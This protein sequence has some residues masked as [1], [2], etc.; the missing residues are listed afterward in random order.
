MHQTKPPCQDISVHDSKLRPP[1]QPDK[2]FNR[3]NSMRLVKSDCNTVYPKSQAE[4]NLTAKITLQ[5]SIVF[6]VEK[7]YPSFEC[8]LD[9]L[10]QTR[11]CPF[12]GR[13][14]SIVTTGVVGF[15]FL[16]NPSVCLASHYQKAFHQSVPIRFNA[17]C[18]VK[19]LSCIF[20]GA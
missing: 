1:R 13:L 7:T 14:I 4:R 8:G 2:D 11:G 12:S 5:S 18:A 9:G 17:P 20:W 6:L 10:N 15:L 16:L 3:T 19:Q